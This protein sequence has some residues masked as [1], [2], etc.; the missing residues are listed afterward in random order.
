MAEH[1]S[2]V[3]SDKLEAIADAIREKT[4]KEDT[5]T[6]D[7]MPDEIRSI[8]GGGGETPQCGIVPTSWASNGYVLTAD[9]YGDIMPEA[10]SAGTYDV[11]AHDQNVP[12]NIDIYDT[13]FSGR[14]ILDYLHSL[15][16]ADPPT[17]IGSEAFYGQYR[18]TCDPLPDGLTTIKDSAFAYCYNIK[19]D[20]IPS[21]VTSIGGYAFAH[22]NNPEELTP[23]YD[24]TATYDIGDTVYYDNN[25]YT[26]IVTISIAEE[27]NSNHWVQGYYPEI[28]GIY[29]PSNTYQNGDIVYDSYQSGVCT[30]YYYNAPQVFVEG[31]AP[32]I[33]GLW[34]AYT[35]YHP[36]D[37]VTFNDYIYTCIE[38]CTNQEPYSGTDSPWSEGY[39]PE[40]IGRYDS[41]QTYSIGDIVADSSGSV[42][43]CCVDISTAEEF[44][45][46]HWV[47]SYCPTL[48]GIY[49]SNV[50]YH[51]GD[52]V[53]YGSSPVF[54][55][56]T[57]IVANSSSQDEFFNEFG[58]GAYPNIEEYSSE[59]T[60][61]VGDIVFVE[62]NYG[63]ITCATCYRNAPAGTSTSDTDYWVEGYY[64]NVSGIYDPNSTY[65]VGTV[66]Y[67]SGYPVVTVARVASPIVGLLYGYTPNLIEEYNP[68]HTYH[69]GD[70][71]AYGDGG[72]SKFVCIS[73]N[74]VTGEWNYSYWSEI[75][76]F[77]LN[78]I[79][80][81]GT[82][83]TIG[84]Y[85]FDSSGYNFILVPWEEGAGPSIDIS[86][87]YVIYGYD[88]ES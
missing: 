28:L 13:E 10:L 52:V 82:P 67:N 16:F 23:N 22:S 6:L 30:C 2:I 7:E 79:T 54:N 40:L 68:N 39:Y 83:E 86:S 15:S 29:N 12:G 44:D 70:V 38:T 74:S 51:M 41:S 48:L 84:Q 59:R 62:L 26:C 19:F 34:D 25:T 43:T 14:Q 27:F 53:A 42:C 88:P 47:S 35:T 37:V 1:D 80:F 65:S 24:S 85:V 75:Y 3:S 11:D 50:T 36:G 78:S 72:S 46:S 20:T 4:N 18:M 56:Y 17:Y 8:S 60:Y 32:S 61:S 33:L 31:S 21:S 87:G 71:V 45:R 9:S 64:E 58:D 57:C 5:M 73:P 63:S 76:D 49:D 55:I 77:V 69:A 81:L 66:L